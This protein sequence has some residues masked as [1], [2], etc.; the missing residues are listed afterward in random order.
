MDEHRKE[1]GVRQ[2]ELYYG[3]GTQ[4]S[5]FAAKAYLAENL[6]REGVVFH[7]TCSFRW[8]S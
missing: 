7:L 3:S 5:R 2:V 8:G 4:L 1:F 6:I